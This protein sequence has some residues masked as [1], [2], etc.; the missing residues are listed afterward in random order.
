MVVFFI[1]QLQFVSDAADKNFLVYIISFSAMAYLYLYGYKKE[2]FFVAIATI[3]N[4][5]ASFLKFI[6]RQPRPATAY[7]NYIFDQYGFPSG[8]T[9][10]YTVLFGFLFYLCFKLTAIPILIRILVVIV[11]IYFISLVGISRVYL[12]Q[13]YVWDVVGGYVFGLL[14]LTALIL[15]DKKLKI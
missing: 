7:N 6:F 15:L 9:V 14:Y 2:T 10:L 12:G 4:L 13:H 3:S 11:S 8:H 1:Q 5:F